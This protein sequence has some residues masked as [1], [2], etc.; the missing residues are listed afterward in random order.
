MVPLRDTDHHVLQGKEETDAEDISRPPDANGWLVSFER[1]HR[2]LAYVDPFDP[3]ADIIGL[4]IPAAA[5]KLPAEP[6]HGGHRRPCPAERIA[7]GAGGRPHVAC[8]RP[9]K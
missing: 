1:H 2:I 9:S 5:K 6:G 3:D 8:V 4:N 7:V